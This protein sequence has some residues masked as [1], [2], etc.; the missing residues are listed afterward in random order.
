MSRF[1]AAALG[2]VIFLGACASASFVDKVT[3]VNG[4]PYSANVDV[5]GKQRDGWLG[6]NTVEPQSTATF[7]QVIDQGEV[8]V[9]RFDY[10]GKY[11]QEVEVS[12]SKLEENDWTV[13]VPESFEHRLGEMGVP[14][15]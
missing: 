1:W 2:T 5:T 10:I 9:F 4:T 8:W 15:P 3:I 14:P 6:L 11:Q 7:D 12:R 13:E